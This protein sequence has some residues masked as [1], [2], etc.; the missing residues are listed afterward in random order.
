LGKGRWLLPYE[1]HNSCFSSLQ[2]FALVIKR[3]SHDNACTFSNGRRDKDHKVQNWEKFLPAIVLPQ[4]LYL[5]PVHPA[6]ACE[7]AVVL[8]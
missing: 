1:F 3:L 5:H 2:F 8:S 7:N 6:L 4:Y